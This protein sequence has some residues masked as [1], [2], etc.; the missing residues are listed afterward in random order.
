ML[1]QLLWVRD[2]ALSS[3]STA[4]LGSPTN[5]RRVLILNPILKSVVRIQPDRLQD[6]HASDNDG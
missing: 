3:L 6:D 4:S 2:A 5:R 1:Y